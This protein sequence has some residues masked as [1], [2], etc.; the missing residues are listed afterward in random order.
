LAS[1]GDR[2]VILDMLRM[3]ATGSGPQAPGQ[4]LANSRSRNP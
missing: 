1:S 2:R 4:S 3:L